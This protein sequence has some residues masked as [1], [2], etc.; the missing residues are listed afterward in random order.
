MEEAK[1]KKKEEVRRRGRLSGG[2]PPSPTLVRFIS[3]GGRYYMYLLLFWRTI[4][5]PCF[6][7]C[8]H[9]LADTPRITEPSPSLLLL[10]PGQ[11]MTLSGEKLFGCMLAD[12]HA[13]LAAEWLVHAVEEEERKREDEEVERMERDDEGDAAA[14]AQTD[15]EPFRLSTDEWYAENDAAA[16]EQRRH[17][18][19]V[20]FAYVADGE[21]L[22]CVVGHLLVLIV[23]FVWGE[24]HPHYF[25]VEC[26]NEQGFGSI[27]RL[28]PGMVRGAIQAAPPR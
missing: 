17:S 19:W 2:S 12:P 4:S 24:V 7:I 22:G 6:T 20:R 3:P 14:R 11:T 9:S 25:L 21:R 8:C 18:A 15:D 13:R 27:P 23:L 28:V 10:R 16:E 26:N 1:K 5:L